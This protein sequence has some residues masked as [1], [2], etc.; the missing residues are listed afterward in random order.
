MWWKIAR[1]SAFRVSGLQRC[2]HRTCIFVRSKKIMNAETFAQTL[3]QLQNRRPFR[4]FT[5]GVVSGTNFTIGRP[6]ALV[7]RDGTAVYI[8]PGGTPWWFDDESVEYFKEAEPRT[9]ASALRKI[10]TR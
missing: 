2:D 6:E 3:R 4:R 5:V 8:A 9:A 10:P 1:E 7:F